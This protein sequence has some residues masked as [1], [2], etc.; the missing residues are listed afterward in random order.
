MWK[1]WLGL[2]RGS[3]KKSIELFRILKKNVFVAVVVLSHTNIDVR[4]RPETTMRGSAVTRHHHMVSNRV[5]NEI[6]VAHAHEC[7]PA[8]IFVKYRFH[9]GK[10]RFRFCLQKVWNFVSQSL[11]EPFELKKTKTKK[12]TNKNFFRSLGRKDSGEKKM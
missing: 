8:C 6:F 11:C 5:G 9:F 2:S 4:S 12:K 1:N 7:F 10:E 3:G